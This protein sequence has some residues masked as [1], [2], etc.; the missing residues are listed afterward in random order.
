MALIMSL[1]SRR[2]VGISVLSSGEHILKRN[3]LVMIQNKG[4]MF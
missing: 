1:M 3:S 2:N 4:D